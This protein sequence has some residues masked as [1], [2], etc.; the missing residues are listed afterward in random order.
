M[1]EALDILQDYDV[2]GNHTLIITLKL[3]LR[4]R[5]MEPKKATNWLKENL[6]VFPKKIQIK[7][8][9]VQGI[10]QIKNTSLLV[11]GVAITKDDKQSY[12]TVPLFGPV[13]SGFRQ[14]RSAAIVA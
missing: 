9:N 10:E 7:N 14:N 12:I 6:P 11:H 4:L 1:L 5:D 2:N 8:V 3:V 13:V